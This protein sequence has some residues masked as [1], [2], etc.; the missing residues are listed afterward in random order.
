M[1]SFVF[2]VIVDGLR[3]VL[4]D[5]KDRER[6]KGKSRTKPFNKGVISDNFIRCLRSI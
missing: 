6:K 4:F 3:S 5:T 1:I 2:S